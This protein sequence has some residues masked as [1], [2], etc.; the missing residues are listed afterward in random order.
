MRLIPILIVLLLPGDLFAVNLTAEQR[1]S[2]HLDGPQLKGE[3]HWLTAGEVRF[4]SILKQSPAESPLGGVILLHD[5]EDNADGPDVIAPLRLRLAQEGWDTLSLQLPRPSAPASASEQAEAVAQAVA[6]L[7][8]A[9]AF[10]KT[11]EV[12]PVSLVGHGL[13]ARMALAYLAG[14]PDDAVQ[15]LVAIGLSPELAKWDEADPVLR[16]LSELQIPTLDLYGDRDRPEVTDSAP[17]R[18]GAAKR[19]DR[20]AY[21]QDRV[22]GADH[23]FSGLQENLQRR[24]ASW[25][26]RVTEEAASAKP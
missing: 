20:E 15:A 21:R 26:L 8:A 25:L 3:A 14:S 19:N 6:R 4:L 23:R 17:A 7:S 5:S 13:G 10:L 1:L 12:V 2:E 16:T 22:M 9:V 18:R 11:R 24:V